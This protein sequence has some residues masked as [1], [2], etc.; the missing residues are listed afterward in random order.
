M[1]PRT[2]SAN[3][4]HVELDTDYKHVYSWWFGVQVLFPLI[5]AI[6]MWYPVTQ[7]IKGVHFSFAKNFAS[8]DLSLFS[9]LLFF[10]VLAEADAV[11]KRAGWITLYRI[12]SLIVGGLSLLIFGISKYVT[13][14]LD[15]PKKVGQ[16]L[17]DDIAYLSNLNFLIGIF[18]VIF[19]SSFTLDIKRRQK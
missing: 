7:E 2:K 1:A 16:I 9:S 14:D 19:V 3:N 12:V 8:G 18:S 10:G 11:K 5:V 6:V 17:P 15:L 13:T 4:S